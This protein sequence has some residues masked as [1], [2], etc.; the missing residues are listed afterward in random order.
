MN[1]DHD[2]VQVWKFSEDQKKASGTLF[3]PNLGE[4][5]KKRSS[6]RLQ[7][8]FSP[9]LRSDVH[10]FKLLGGMQV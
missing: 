6:T 7:Y 9:N 1:L 2:F 4:D 10:P 3:S 8:F 5:Q